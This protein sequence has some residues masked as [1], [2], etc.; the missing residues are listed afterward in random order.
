MGIRRIPVARL[1]TE[2]H[3]LAVLVLSCLIGLILVLRCF[4]AV[5]YPILFNEDGTRV[6]A[7]YLNNPHLSAVWQFYAG[8]VALLP[9]LIGYIIVA[10]IP[11][12]AVPYFLVAVSVAL[13]VAPLMMFS[14]KRFR[15][16]LPDDGTRLLVC[17]IL[18]FFP[19]GNHALVTNLTFSIINIFAIALLLLL[20]ELPGSLA[21]RIIQFVLV[22]LAVFSHPFSILFVPVCL[23]LILLRRT[24]ADRIFNGG[25]VGLVGIY[26]LVGVHPSAAGLGL[27]LPSLQAT[28]ECVLQRVLFEPVLGNSLRMILYQAGQASITNLAGVGIMALLVAVIAQRWREPALRNR[29]PVLGFVLF[30]IAGLTYLA[31]I[32]RNNLYNSFTELAWGQRYFLVQ[33]ILVLLVLV[34]HAVGLTGWDRLTVVARSAVA[35]FMLVF[36]A[37][38]NLQHAPYFAT[39]RDHG[40]MTMQFLRDVDSRL[41]QGGASRGGPREMVLHRE[42]VWDIKINIRPR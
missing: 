24:L 5:F 37:Y 2:H 18:A 31:V 40:K 14:L 27:S 34:V 29:V 28:A 3:T 1:I 39:S 32:G 20:A 23:A 42:G 10:A 35:V 4:N 17:L 6:V 21:G 33:Q 25:I 38:L 11:L 19:L 12:R 16:I 13:A 30:V 8:Y 15:F 7:F 9:N 41:H 22:G 26:Y 36:A